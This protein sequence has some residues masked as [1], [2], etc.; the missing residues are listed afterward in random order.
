VASE[1]TWTP[2]CLSRIS[3]R[4]TAIS[5]SRSE[6]TGDESLV[7]LLASNLLINSRLCNLYRGLKYDWNFCNKSMEYIFPKHFIVAD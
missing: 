6:H 5:I 3:G 1:Q 7:I 4:S 2:Q